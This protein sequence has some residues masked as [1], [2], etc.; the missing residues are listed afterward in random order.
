MHLPLRWVAILYGRVPVDFAITSGVHTHEDVVKGVMA[1]DN[2]T[3]LASELLRNGVE[4][5]GQID[6][7]DAWQHEPNQRGQTGCL[8]AGQLYACS[9]FVA[10]RF[11]LAY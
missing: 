6:H 11:R 3:M 9:R 1:G 2:V 7:P 5:I 4:R 10:T 8:R